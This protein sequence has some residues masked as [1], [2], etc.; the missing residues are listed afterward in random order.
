[1]NW[2]KRFADATLTGVDGS[3]Q[4][5]IRTGLRRVDQ[6]ALN[7][8]R[9]QLHDGNVF[10][11][12]LQIERE[13]AKTT[14]TIRSRRISELERTANELESAVRERD[15]KI[16]A[17]EAKRTELAE[18]ILKMYNENRKAGCQCKTKAK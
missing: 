3:S 6:D 9:Q 10:R 7:W 8:V 14:D 5:I 2:F 16:A 17:L 1:M 15:A 11:R 4:Y 13:Q 18:I 12:C